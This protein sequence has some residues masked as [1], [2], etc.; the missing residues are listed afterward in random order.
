MTLSNSTISKRLTNI[1]EIYT[2]VFEK[3]HG[4]LP[5]CEKDEQWIS[6]CEL[7]AYD[8]KHNHWQPVVINETLSFTNVEEAL[9]LPLHQS[10]KDY[11]TV[12][13]SESILARCDEGQL[14]LIFAWNEADFA[15]LQENIIGHLLMKKRLKQEATIFFAVTD[16]DDYIISLKNDSGEVWVERVGGDP[17]KKLADNMLAFLNDLTI[18]N[19][20]QLQ[21]LNALQNLTVIGSENSDA[22]TFM[23]IQNNDNLAN[24]DGLMSL[25][26]VYGDV[27]IGSYID[28]GNLELGNENL[29]DFC[30][31]FNLVNNGLFNYVNVFNNAFNPTNQDI[32][33]G[34]C[35][36]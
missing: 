22:L 1:G 6:P 35:S 14:S 12:L 25:E 10:I 9:D 34:N 21:D 27:T 5:V 18:D 11:F 16:D 13:Y 31:I 17:H 20:S 7:T 4:F 24:L 23:I 32:I 3:K 30:G 29:T 36:Q 2:D 19:N 28:D 15:R 8:D 33:D 26:A